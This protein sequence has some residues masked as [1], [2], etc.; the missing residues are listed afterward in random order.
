MHHYC[1]RRGDQLRLV[2]HR[3]GGAHHHLAY[4]RADH[5]GYPAG[6]RTTGRDNH[7]GGYL[8]LH[9]RPRRSAHRG[10]ANAVRGV[11]TNRYCPL[12]DRHRHCHVGGELTN[13]RTDRAIL[14]IAGC[15]SINQLGEH[16][17]QPGF[18]AF[19]NGFGRDAWFHADGHTRSDGAGL[20]GRRHRNLRSG[21]HL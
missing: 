6:R 11:H 16:E 14:R 3:A 7:G 2:Y 18:I 5:A 12:D 20:Y 17:P 21:D 10:I 15:D 13:C 19:H 9:T 1:G 4:A 8:C